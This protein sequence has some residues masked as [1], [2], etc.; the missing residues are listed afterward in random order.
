MRQAHQEHGAT[1][2]QLK[3][4]PEGSKD[5]QSDTGLSQRPAGGLGFM[6]TCSLLYA[7]VLASLTPDMFGQN[8][9]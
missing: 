6:S 9:L 3:V 7:L 4:Q 1:A 5:A 8:Y 2:D